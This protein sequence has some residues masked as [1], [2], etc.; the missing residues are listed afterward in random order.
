MVVYD[1]I[2]VFGEKRIE[3]IVAQGMWVTAMGS[4]DH[5]VRYVDNAHSQSRSHL[6]KE[7]RSRDNF[8][9]HFHADTNKDA[10]YLK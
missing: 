10:G 9:R 5:E 7:R 2:L 1:N 8:E 6:A 4:E 3:V